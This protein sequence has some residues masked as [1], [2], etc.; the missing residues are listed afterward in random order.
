MSNN[1]YNE[2]NIAISYYIEEIENQEKENKEI[3]IEEF[4]S[5]L[6]NNEFNDDLAVPKMINYHENY[7]VKELLLICDY[8]GFAKELKTNKCNKDQIIEILVSFESDLNNSDI[9]FKRQNMWFY[10]NELKN[11][12]FMKK[13][14]LW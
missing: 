1:N 14:V 3:N 4:M 2:Q 11:D 9:V 10:I 6:E 12:K 5:E 8:Y 13:Y 7:T